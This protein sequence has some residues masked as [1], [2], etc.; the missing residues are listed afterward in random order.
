MHRPVLQVR[1]CLD[2]VG[3][4]SIHVLRWIGVELELNFIPIHT[5][6]HRIEVNT[7][8]SKQDAWAN[9]RARTRRRQRTRV[10][11]RWA[12][13]GRLPSPGSFHRAQQHIYLDRWRTQ[14]SPTRRSLRRWR[15][16][17][18]CRSAAA[19]VCAGALLFGGAAQAGV[20]WR[21]ERDDGGGGDGPATALVALLTYCCLDRY[22]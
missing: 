22:R 19:A 15:G 11:P 5:N 2:V 8:T 10:A 1:S 18:S 20:E 9:C 21:R 4:T 16:T 7:T 14:V 3:F 13:L 17:G 6:T 12:R